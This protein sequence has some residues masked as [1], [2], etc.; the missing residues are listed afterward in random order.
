MPSRCAVTC[1]A[2]QSALSLSLAL[3]AASRPA[4]LRL[5]WLG[6]WTLMAAIASLSVGGGAGALPSAWS[7]MERRS[8]FA[9]RRCS[10]G[11]ANPRA[12]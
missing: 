8:R 5:R 1:C 2:C 6:A 3:A 4:S 10:S 11:G 9:R 12:G 7:L